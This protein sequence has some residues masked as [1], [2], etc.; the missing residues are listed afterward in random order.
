MNSLHIIKKA[1]WILQALAFVIPALVAIIKDSS[2]T[3]LYI[4][5][6][7]GVVQ[8]VSYLLNLVLLDDKYK[9][10]HRTPYGWML[11]IVLIAT[12]LAAIFR[13]PLFGSIILTLAPVMAI[14]YFFISVNEAS[15]LGKLT[16]RKRYI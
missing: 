12:I 1:D 8:V 4:P 14:L 13:T 16:R 11:L 5:I 7:V 15:Y 2:L 3:F 6:Y 9:S 10:G